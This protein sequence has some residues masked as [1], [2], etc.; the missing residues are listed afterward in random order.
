MVSGDKTW[1]MI[2][3]ELLKDLL[4]SEEMALRFLAIFKEQAPKEL[5]SIR[6][7]AAA[8]NWKEASIAAHGL[9]SQLRYLSLTSEANLAS[10]LENDAEA[11]HINWT[12]LAELEW[13]LKLVLEQTKATG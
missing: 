12:N 7:S 9:K 1:D 4:G 11:G 10:N 5:A 2:D 6:Q 3:I 13:R 8:G